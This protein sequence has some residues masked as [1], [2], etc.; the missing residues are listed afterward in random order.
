MNLKI[1]TLLSF[2]VIFSC[3]DNERQSRSSGHISSYNPEY[4]NYIDGSYGLKIYNEVPTIVKLEY[5]SQNRIIKRIGGYNPKYIEPYIFRDKIYNELHYSSGQIIIEIGGRDFRGFSEKHILKL[6]SKNRIIQREVKI[7]NGIDI[8]SIIT[9]YKYNLQG[10]IISSFS[11]LESKPKEEKKS[12]ISKYYKSSKYY[13]NNKENLDS[14]VSLS[15]NIEKIVYLFED[16]DNKP[17]PL[18]NLGI[19]EETFFRSLSN[20]N[21][22]TYKK[23]YY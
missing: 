12:N 11:I 8:S 2:F 6:D 21:Y 5:D 3:T 23:L 22:S 7:D 15:R 13:Y 9:N 18:K 16:F 14:I 10:K 17:N 20:N 1:F 4:M 19:F